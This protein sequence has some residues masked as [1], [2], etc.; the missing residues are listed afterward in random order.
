MDPAT[1]ATFEE[2]KEV[3]Y[4]REESRPIFDDEK[5]AQTSSVADLVA[6]VNNMKDQ[7]SFLNNQIV[8]HQEELYLL[9]SE[10]LNDL[11]I[12][13][14]RTL[15]KDYSPKRGEGW[16]AYLERLSSDK[17]ALRI[18]DLK[19]SDVEFIAKREKEIWHRDKREFVVSKRRTLALVKS[20]CMK[21]DRGHYMRF[22][23]YIASVNPTFEASLPAHFFKKDLPLCC[24]RLLEAKQRLGFSFEEIAKE[25][26]RD[27]V[28]VAS[29]FMGKTSPNDTD[30]KR[31][32]SKLQLGHDTLLGDFITAGYPNRGSS[33]PAQIPS[34]PLLY[35]LHEALSVYGPGIRS[36]IQEK[37]GD[38]VM[39]AVDFTVKLDKLET[40]KGDRVV[41]TMD[42]KFLPYK[43]W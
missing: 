18:R 29:L 11:I 6:C 21:I 5:L 24:V 9:Y 39:S 16:A 26:E 15:E 20:S 3:S 4:E 37:F 17:N 10:L 27:E 2:N 31:L 25:L 19:P 23:R 22:F 32:A 36:V 28:W 12:L 30:I 42:G 8:G 38:G 34:D 7:I 33:T 43:T 13:A 1:S 40:P 41:L 35:R 14:W